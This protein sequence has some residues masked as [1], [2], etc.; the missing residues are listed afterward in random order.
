MK[1]LYLFRIFLLKKV[2][3]GLKRI[4]SRTENGT[5]VACPSYA[6][7][8]TSGNKDPIDIKFRYDSVTTIRCNFQKS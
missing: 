3:G 7:D 8:Q 6:M 4:L 2:F 5:F 1:A